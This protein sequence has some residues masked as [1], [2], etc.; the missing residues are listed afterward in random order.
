M[1]FNPSSPNFVRGVNIRTSQSPDR[2][3]T[4]DFLIPLFHVHLAG[5]GFAPQEVGDYRCHKNDDDDD[6][7]D[8]QH[9]GQSRNL[10]VDERRTCSSQVLQN[11]GSRCRRGKLKNAKTFTTD[12][13]CDRS[14][15][16]FSL[17]IAHFRRRL[18]QSYQWVIRGADFAK[19]PRSEENSAQAAAFFTS[20]LAMER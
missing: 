13:Q 17:S 18:I 12:R 3:P 2:S 11:S 6:D 16:I 9:R 10:V 20:L 14:W 7:D 5:D 19:L 4:S 8:R 1:K 15:I